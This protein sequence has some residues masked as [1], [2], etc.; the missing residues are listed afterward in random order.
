M[1]LLRLAAIG[2]AIV[3]LTVGALPRYAAADAVTVVTR[4]CERTLELVRDPQ[5]TTAERERQ[6]GALVDSHF[7]FPAIASFVLGRFWQKA[8]AD[9][10]RDFTAAFKAHMV[11]AYIARFKILYTGETFA[12]KDPRPEGDGVTIVPVQILRP[13]GQP[14]LVLDWKVQGASADQRIRDISIAGVSMARTYRDEFTSVIL[15]S[16]GRVAVLIAALRDRTGEE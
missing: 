1:R 12:V 5:I 15:R 4:F 13:G 16:E 8:S 14:P 7:D 2:L 9:E 3:L 11:R 10:R 6:F